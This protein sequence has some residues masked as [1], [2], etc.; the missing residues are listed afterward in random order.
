MSYSPKV[1][2][3]DQTYYK[4]QQ[5]PAFNQEGDAFVYQIH[6]TSKDWHPNN[7]LKTLPAPYLFPS[8]TETEA[9][10]ENIQME[11][12]FVSGKPTVPLPKP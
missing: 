6:Q 8:F 2:L 7:F 3:P 4:T 11:K 5:R 10:L 9:C 12:A 1:Q